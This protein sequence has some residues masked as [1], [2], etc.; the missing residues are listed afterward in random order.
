VLALALA[1][2]DAQGGRLPPAPRRLY[3]IAWQRDLVERPGEWRPVEPGGPAFDPVTRLVVAGTRDGWLR[4]LRPDGSVAW[5]FRGGGAFSGDVAIDGDTAYVGCDDGRLYAVAVTTGVERW[6]YEA[7]EQLATRPVIRDGL[8]FVA[9]LQD[10]IYALDARTGAWRWHHRREQREGFTIRGAAGVR[11]EGGTVF[12]G[13]SDGAVVAVEAVTGRVRWERQVAPSGDYL[14]VDS[15]VVEGGKVYAAAYSGAVAALE[16]ATGTPAWQ[17]PVPEASRLVMASGTL[18]C[19]TA[20]SVVGLSP[21]DGRTLWSAAIDGT[22]AGEPVTEGRW[23]LVPAGDGGLRFL[24]AAGGRAVRV[25]Q[26]GTGVSAT[27]AV[28]G[29]RAFVLSNGGDL[30]ALDLR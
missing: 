16:A 28:G 11:V 13:F 10:A 17:V 18:I 3:A 29:G 21:V 15:L 22:P 24:E 25:L 27:P 1:A 23:L 2:V 30:L 14:D 26:P 7:R 4:G 9:S 12:G 5:S 8:V 6:H 20:R 19:V